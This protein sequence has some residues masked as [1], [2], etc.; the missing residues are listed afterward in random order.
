MEVKTGKQLD[1]HDLV[2]SSCTVFL[3]NV[4]RNKL[5]LSFLLFNSL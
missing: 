1:G 2:V 5:T 3:L 4:I